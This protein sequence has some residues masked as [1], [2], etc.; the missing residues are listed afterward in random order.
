MRLAVESTFESWLLGKRLA[1]S[2]I[3]EYRRTID[4][5]RRIAAGEGLDIDTLDSHATR[6][7]AEQV[8][9]STRKAL[10]SALS[11][12]WPMVGY[13]GPLDAILVDT[14][15]DIDTYKGLSESDAAR[16]ER[17]ARQSDEGLVVL[18]GLYLGLRRSEIA[19]LRWEDFDGGLEWVRI[20][21]KGRR[22]R[23]LPVHRD[24]VPALDGG[25]GWVF[26]GRKGHIHVGTIYTWTDRVAAAAGVGHV[27]P[28]ALRHTCL[29]RLYRATNDLRLV[30]R[31]AGHST[32]M[33]TERYTHISRDDL[34]GGIGKLT[35]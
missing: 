30:Q 15:S 2:T 26:P 3:M 19:A 32:S 21:G 9:R 8:P 5:A 10:R 14:E 29:S 23:T 4:R 12:Y 28:H 17:Q 33:T 22:R 24:L 31:F 18:V 13:D 11:H 16:I 25:D 20:L 27:H 6:W 35:Y 34:A 1:E 7:L